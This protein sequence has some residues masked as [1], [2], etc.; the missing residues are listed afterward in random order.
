M[1]EG[2]ETA[3]SCCLVASRQN[4][5]IVFLDVASVR[6][7]RTK[8]VVRLSLCVFPVLPQNDTPICPLKK[9][10]G[11]RRDQSSPPQLCPVTTVPDNG[12]GLSTNYQDC[13]LSFVVCFSALL[14]TNRNKEYE[15]IVHPPE[16]A[17]LRR[18]AAPRGCKVEDVP[19]LTP[20]SHSR[21]PPKRCRE[22]ATFPP[23]HERKCTHK[24]RLQQGQRASAGE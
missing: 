18:G 7:N 13:C 24:I 19:S 6:Q 21:S 10:N 20:R 16:C 17:H 11:P 9:Y 12:C 23:E 22:L 4:E 8:R 15:G 14:K 3:V 5:V 2:G 1:G